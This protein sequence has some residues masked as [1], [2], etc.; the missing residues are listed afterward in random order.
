MEAIQYRGLTEED[1]LEAA[2]F[3][4]RIRNMIERMQRA[5]FPLTNG[6]VEALS[7]CIDVLVSAPPVMQE[8][9]AEVS[10]GEPEPIPAAVKPAATRK[11]RP[12]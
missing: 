8:P 3:H 6:D 12:V 1:R 9:S 7:F 10:A 11:M 5:G 4:D 2:I